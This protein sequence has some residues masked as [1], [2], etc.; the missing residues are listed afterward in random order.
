[1][2]QFTRE[3]KLNYPSV[4]RRFRSD[5]P[6][7]GT[8]GNR[9][10]VLPFTIVVARNGTIAHTQIGPLKSD[11]LQ[12]GNRP[13]LVEARVQIVRVRGPSKRR[14]WSS[15]PRV[16]RPFWTEGAV[17]CRQALRFWTKVGYRWTTCAYL[18][19][20]RLLQGL[21]G[22]ARRWANIRHPAEPRRRAT[23]KCC[24]KVPR[25]ARTSPPWGAKPGSLR[26]RGPSPRSMRRLADHAK[27]LAVDL[28][29]F[30]SNEVVAL[31]DRVHSRC[32]RWGSLHRH[33]S[34]RSS[35]IP[36]RHCVTRCRRP[37]S[38][39]SKCILTNV[40]VREPFSPAFQFFR[41]D[42]WN[43]RRSRSAGL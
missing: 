19:Q 8:F 39:S 10:M 25:I 26:P 41:Q 18:R 33:R 2:Q 27:K 1:V 21:Q 43:H 32:R 11:R 34:G 35:P 16:Y 40:N 5:R 9:L 36:V 30:Q 22:S 14:T 37:P 15:H 42:G 31:I 24:P 13:L 12:Q 4:N 38:R 3:I 6:L 28:V 7:Q 23:R 20:T 17:Y 29:A